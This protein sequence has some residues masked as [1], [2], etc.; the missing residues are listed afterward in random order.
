VP[1]K[2][3]I[4]DFV[5]IDKVRADCERLKVTVY[6][7]L[8]DVGTHREVDEF[9]ALYGCWCCFPGSYGPC[10]GKAPREE[11]PELLFDQKPERRAYLTRGEKREMARIRELLY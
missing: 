11:S 10:Y 1:I 7:Y 9:L 3:R 8:S 4:V 6:Q 5:V 2:R